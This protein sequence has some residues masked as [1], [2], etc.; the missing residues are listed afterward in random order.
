MFSEGREGASETNWLNETK[1]I[2]FNV[3]DWFLKNCLKENP[4]KPNLLLTSKGETFI[5]IE[6]YIIKSS[7]SKK[8]LRVSIDNLRLCKKA[9]QKLVALT[10]ISSYISTNESRL[11][12]IAFFSS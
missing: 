7:A 11:I 4:A 3:L 8:L 5:K 10:R 9:S 2:A 12:I 6:G 1:N